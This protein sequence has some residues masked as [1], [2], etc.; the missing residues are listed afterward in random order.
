MSIV[1]LILSKVPPVVTVKLWPVFVPVV[2]LVTPWRFDVVTVGET[3]FAW[4]VSPEQIV[5]EVLATTGLGLTV[6][7]TVNGVPEQSTVAKVAVLIAITAIDVPGLFFAL[8]LET[9][10]EYM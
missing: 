4:K 8:L 10:T 9:F 3:K 2:T 5:W 6:T 7:V 1:A